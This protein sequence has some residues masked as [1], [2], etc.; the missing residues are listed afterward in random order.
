MSRK[1]RVNADSVGLHPRWPI[2]LLFG[3][4]GLGFGVWAAMI[5]YFQHRLGLTPSDLGVPLFALV[6]G[7]LLSMPATGS[8]V[9][10][11]GSRRPALPVVIGYAVALASIALAAELGWRMAFTVAAFAFGC[12]KGMLDVIV[13]TQAVALEEARR[14]PV[15]A[16]CQGCW[17][18]GGLAGAAI[19]SLALGHLARGAVLVFGV[20]VA[21]V[22]A[23]L[24]ARPR[25]LDGH[26]RGPARRVGVLGALRRSPRL[27]ILGALALL[28]LFAEGVMAD[29]AA[30]YLRTATGVT[31]ALAAA[32]YAVFA[33]AMT[34]GRFSGDGV[35]RRLG[36]AAV[37]RLGGGL[38]FLGMAIAVVAGGWLQQPVGV[39]AGFVVVGLG[40]A[41]LVPVLFSA[42]G[43]DPVAGPGPGIATV[44]TLGF[45]GFLIG[46]PIIAGLSAV[47]GLS[48][49]LG[50]VVLAGA[51]IA[52]TAHHVPDSPS[53]A[54]KPAI[55]LP[56]ASRERAATV[57]PLS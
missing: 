30:V 14:R 39:V 19:V 29:W 10:R 26:A 21:L 3:A 18:C 42:A 51:A 47:V 32:G 5:P 22:V 45:A 57:S 17:S 53:V 8:L 38:A 4:D 23:A 48:C 24:V 28:A 46:P 40:L 41:N 55:T 2:V 50:L 37:L 1:L 34:V 16:F 49:A 33:G 52:L 13:N 43:R 20:S 54:A 9:A 25:L 31:T 36:S 44:T 11:W 15:N 7:A 56:V 6:T 27:R 35:I 12:G